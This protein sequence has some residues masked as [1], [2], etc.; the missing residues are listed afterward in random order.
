MSIRRPISSLPEFHGLSYSPL[1][2]RNHR[3]QMGYRFSD[4]SLNR[5]DSSI[6]L[7][8]FPGFINVHTDSAILALMMASAIAGQGLQCRSVPRES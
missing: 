5:Q 4:C 2:D 8:R 3:G 1:G 6:L 7:S